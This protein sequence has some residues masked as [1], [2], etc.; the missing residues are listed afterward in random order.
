MIRSIIFGALLWV[1]TLYVL[2]RGTTE[3]R[4]AAAGMFLNSYL[5]WIVVRPFAIRYSDFETSVIYLDSLLLALLLWIALRSNKFWP[6]WLTAMQALATFA[7]FAPYVP[8]IIPWGYGTA[9]AIWM[10]PMLIVLLMATRID[11]QDRQNAAVAG[12]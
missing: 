5:T 7:H 1:T 11:Y 6:I 3:E 9:V 4:L 2:R 8:H 10:Y 12:Y